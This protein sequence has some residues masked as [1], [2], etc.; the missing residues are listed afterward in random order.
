MLG[1]LWDGSTGVGTD[2][3]AGWRPSQQQLI[4]LVLLA[5]IG[6]AGLYFSVSSFSA[7]ESDREVEATPEA[8]LV[9]ADETVVVTVRE[10]GSRDPV[11][12]ATVVP[13]ADSLPLDAAPERTTN[14]SGRAVFTFGDGPGDVTPDWRTGVDSAAVRFEVDPPDETQVDR[15]ANAP[16]TV[17]RS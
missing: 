12:G 16:V 8:S 7:I 14:A 17:L 5:V 10:A 9:E 15:L 6:T 2:Q 4:V 11:A 1:T 3:R 13:T